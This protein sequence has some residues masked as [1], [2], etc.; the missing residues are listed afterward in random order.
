MQET[1]RSQYKMAKMDIITSLLKNGYGLMIIYPLYDD[2]SSYNFTDGCTLASYLGVRK[3]FLK[4]LNLTKLLTVKN[5][6]KLAP[7]VPNGRR[8]FVWV[9]Y[10]IS[11]VNPFQTYVESHRISTSIQLKAHFWCYKLIFWVESR[12]IWAEP[13]HFWIDPPWPQVLLEIKIVQ[14]Q[15]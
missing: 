11:T 3:H 4:F 14:I 6:L 2:I 5:W 1:C 12:C 8:D 13:G 7:S 15:P 10:V 9:L